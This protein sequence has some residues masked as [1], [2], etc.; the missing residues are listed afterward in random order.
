[1]KEKEYIDIEELDRETLLK[2]YKVVA[3]QLTDMHKYY[4]PKTTMSGLI[5]MVH[6]EVN[7]LQNTNIEHMM[8]HEI[9]ENQGKQN[10]YI[11]VLHMIQLIRP[12]D[13]PFDKL[14]KAIRKKDLL[15]DDIL[16]KHHNGASWE[17]LEDVPY[18]DEAYED[19]NEI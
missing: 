5:E 17:D 8:G 2:L 15:K 4:E 19:N 6:K 7:K 1:M 10:A 18:S 12:D 13:K 9:Y 11:H 3:G 16:D 14:D